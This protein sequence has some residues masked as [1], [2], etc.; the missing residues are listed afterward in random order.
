MENDHTNTPSPCCSRLT[1]KKK[2]RCRHVWLVGLL[3]LAAVVGLASHCS[4]NILGVFNPHSSWH[5][6]T[7]WRSPIEAS[8]IATHLQAGV[9]HLFY[10]ATA[11]DAQ[12]AQGHSIITS[13]TS[14]LEAMI[15]AH[16]TLRSGL[17][18][19]LS[20]PTVDRAKL[21]ALR[22]KAIEQADIASK[23]TMKTVG[24][25]AEVLTETQ[26]KNLANQFFETVQP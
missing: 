9:D 21:E 24:D 15:D 17:I 2:C 25:L 14:D 16:R 8:A 11:S 26:R 12:K 3:L 23:R 20:A 7:H 5:R 19:A 13:A 1:A 22:L 18:T 10:N 4:N 6:H